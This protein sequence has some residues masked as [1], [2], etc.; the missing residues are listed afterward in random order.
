[1]LEI[2]ERQV[3]NENHEI[4]VNLNNLAAVYAAQGKLEAAEQMY[5]RS[6][7]IKEKLLGADHPDT[8]VTLNNLALLIKR[9]GELTR[10]ATMYSRALTIFERA[11]QPTHPCLLTCRTNYEKLQRKL[12]RSVAN[13]KIERS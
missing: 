9:R 8:A 3:G 5:C 6:L 11:L 2:F 4:A 10:A 1:V 12:A 7:A 13:K